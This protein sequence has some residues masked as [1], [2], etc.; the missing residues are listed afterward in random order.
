MISTHD[1]DDSDLY[2]FYK[3][4]KDME[5]ASDAMKRELENGKSNLAG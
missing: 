5:L 4:R 3:D 1:I 2:K